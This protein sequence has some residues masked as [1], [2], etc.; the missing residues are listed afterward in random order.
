V[1]SALCV[2]RNETSKTAAPGGTE[3]V[4]IYKQMVISVP[5][6]DTLL[7]FIFDTYTIYRKD[8]QQQ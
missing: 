7:Q 8:T 6:F 5:S 1:G 2:W 3:Q 4:F